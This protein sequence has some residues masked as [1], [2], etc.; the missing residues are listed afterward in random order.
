[1]EPRRP[2]MPKRVSFS[3]TFLAVIACLGSGRS[4][5]AQSASFKVD[6]ETSLAWWQINPHLNHLWATTCPADPDWRAGDGSSF[7]NAR[8]LVALAQKRRGYAA[9]LDTIIPLYPRQEV[10]PV[11]TPAVRGE[12]KVE[13]ASAWRGVRGAVVVRAEALVTGLRMRDDYASRA[14]LQSARYPEISFRIDSLAAVQPGDTLRAEVVGMFELHGVAEPMRVPVKAWR[15]AGGL[16]VTGRFD[17]R[18]TELL[19]KYG[20]SRWALGLGV[21][22]NIWK[23]VHM[24][25]DVVLREQASRAE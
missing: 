10:K 3:L 23:I 7:A 21:G 13:D 25:V 24:G 20:L 19:D 2:W 15:E 6:A 18:A 16:R 17:V 4:L 8:S 14:V 9:I 22:T 5:L 12:V 1:M 11:C